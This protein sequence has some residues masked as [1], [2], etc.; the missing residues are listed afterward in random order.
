MPCCTDWPREEDPEL[1]DH[2]AESLLEPGWAGELKLTEAKHIAGELTKSTRLRR[3]WRFRKQKRYPLALIAERAFPENPVLSRRIIRNQLEQ[4]RSTARESPTD[5]EILPA[6]KPESVRKGSVG[7]LDPPAGGRAYR[8][9]SSEAS[10]A[11][12]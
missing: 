10:I 3:A 12:G 11:V 2:Y 8:L 6:A 5:S 1:H 7:T 9:T 4:E